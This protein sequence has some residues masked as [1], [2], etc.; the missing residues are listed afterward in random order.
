MYDGTGGGL[1]SRIVGI[2]CHIKYLN[3]ANFGPAPKKSFLLN[4][5]I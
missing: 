5:T 4:Q 2:F 1:Y 3:E